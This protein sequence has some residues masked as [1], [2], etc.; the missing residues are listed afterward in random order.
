M[1]AQSFLLQLPHGPPSGS[2][3]LPVMQKHAP[4]GGGGGKHG[5]SAMNINGLPDP[6]GGGANHGPASLATATATA[7][8]QQQHGHR[9]FSLYSSQESL[10]S[11]SAA[12]SA[13]PG[14]MRHGAGTPQFQNLSGLVQQQREQR[15]REQHQ[16]SKGKSCGSSSGASSRTLGESSGSPSS[17]TEN[18]ANQTPSPSDSAVGDLEVMLKE[19][20][21]EINYLR[22]TMEQNE[23]VIFKVRRHNWVTDT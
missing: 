1:R 3:S 12:G 8:Q 15:E 16:S 19:K 22:E 5:L 23:Q 7:A 11:S 10:R 17:S 2:E 14:G 9:G 18:G 20:D 6:F 21:T 4:G 13:P